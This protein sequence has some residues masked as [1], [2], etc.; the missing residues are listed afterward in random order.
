MEA[1]GNVNQLCGDPEI[2]PGFANAALENGAGIQLLAYR[3]QVFTRLGIAKGRSP[4]YHVKRF[5]LRQ[6]I[7]NL[8]R[9]AFTEV[10]LVVVGAHIGKRQH[11]DGGNGVVFCGDLCRDLTSNPGRCNIE[12]PGEDCG[13]READNGDDNQGSHRPFR[14]TKWLEG[15]LANL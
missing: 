3:L 2:I 8:L 1:I 9:D 12:H 10:C 14:E 7:E 15:H 4:R 13:D 5:N 11:G 6:R